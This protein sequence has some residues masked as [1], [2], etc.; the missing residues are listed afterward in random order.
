MMGG[1]VG[2]GHEPAFSVPRSERNLAVGN[3]PRGHGKT[4]KLRPSFF[5]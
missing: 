3:V 1:R 4:T 2:A 5:V